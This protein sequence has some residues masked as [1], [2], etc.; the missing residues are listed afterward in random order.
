MPPLL[1]AKLLTVIE[2]REFFRVGGTRP[3]RVDVRFLAATNQNLTALLAS[4]RFREDLYYR[5]NVMEIR[6]PP[7]RERAEDIK[8][9]AR[10]FLEKHARKANKAIAGFTPEALAMLRSYGFPG[11]VRELENI[12]ERAVILEKSD[13]IQPASLPQSIALFQVEA[14][15]ADRVKTL[16]ELNREYAEKVLEHVEQNR[17]KAAALLGISRT[18]LWRILRRDTEAEG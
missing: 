14:L 7:L 3:I 5:L 11:N 16:D 8:P 17:A 1:Q 9:L 18:S 15:A 6:V 10:H 13:R 12:V 4:G 2:E